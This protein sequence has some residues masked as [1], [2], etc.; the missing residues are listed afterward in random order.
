VK[1]PTHVLISE[2]IQLSRNGYWLHL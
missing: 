1:Y 2:K